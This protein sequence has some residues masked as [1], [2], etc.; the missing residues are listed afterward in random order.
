MFFIF[1][2]YFLALIF[3]WLIGY[4]L[5]VRRKEKPLFWKQFKRALVFFFLGISFSVFIG[6]LYMCAPE[7]PPL[8][9][10]L[11]VFPF[12]IPFIWGISLLLYGF[13]VSK[14]KNAPEDILDY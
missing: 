14:H 8:V 9:G 13:F 5:M 7:L 2:I 4:F 1:L 10:I 6:F 12:L 11:A 3:I